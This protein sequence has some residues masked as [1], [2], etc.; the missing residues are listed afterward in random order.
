MQQFE[1]LEMLKKKLW[2]QNINAVIWWPKFIL[3]TI[4]VN[5]LSCG[6][7][8]RFQFQFQWRHK[9]I[10]HMFGTKT[11][12]MDFNCKKLT[13]LTHPWP[14]L[15][16]LV[17]FLLG[18]PTETMLLS[19]SKI[20]SSDIFFFFCSCWTPPWCWTC[21]WGWWWSFFNCGVKVVDGSKG[22]V[23]W[24]RNDETTINGRP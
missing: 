17:Y 6:I 8:L 9:T 11:S 10:S 19:F 2:L 15:S 24:M 23:Y 1:P 7:S 14:I 5:H 22:F 16:C 4:Y 18:S 3:L 21:C 12:S 13:S 20:S